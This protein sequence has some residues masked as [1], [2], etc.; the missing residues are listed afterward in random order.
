MRII[1]TIEKNVVTI[2]FTQ[3]DDSPIYT[4]ELDEDGSYL[5]HFT[6][7]PTDNFIGRQRMTMADLAYFDDPAFPKKCAF[8]PDEF[9]ELFNYGNNLL[10]SLKE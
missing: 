6:L 5:H 3:Y 9:R 10:L 2:R 1:H 8:G 7:A 4:M